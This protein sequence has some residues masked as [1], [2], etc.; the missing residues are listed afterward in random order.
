MGW[1]RLRARLGAHL[2]L[3]ALALNLVVSFGHLHWGEVSAHDAGAIHQALNP[4]APDHDTPA[5][6]D[7][8]HHG[9]LHPCFICTVA[10]AAPFA[11]T[12]PDLP[13]H[14]ATAMARFIAHPAFELRENRRTAFQSRAPPHA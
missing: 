2:A 1:F 11:A 13:P 9:P 7:H 12:A 14:H 5:D 4:A 6:H 10:M 3:L 8:N